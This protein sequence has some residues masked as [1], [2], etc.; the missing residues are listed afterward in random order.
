[1]TYSLALHRGTLPAQDILQLGEVLDEGH[2]LCL[3][4]LRMNVLHGGHLQRHLHVALTLQEG[5]WLAIPAW[6]TQGS[7]RDQGAELQP[8]RHVL[9]TQN[10][11]ITQQ[12]KALNKWTCVTYK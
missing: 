9:Q 4:T 3:E 5:V 11:K 2:H 1:M 7:L 8:K 6:D 12:Q 10:S